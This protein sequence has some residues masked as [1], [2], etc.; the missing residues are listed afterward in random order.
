M[1]DFRKI[2]NLVKLLEA[3]SDVVRDQVLEEL[4]HCAAELAAY[5]ESSAAPPAPEV[6]Y[7]LDK[8][9][10]DFHDRQSIACWLDWVDERDEHAKLEAA[11]GFL[12]GVE[13][14]HSSA[15][16]LRSG[17]D[18]LAAEF[19]AAKLPVEVLMLN[20]YLFVEGRLRGVERNYYHP[21]H[22]NPCY[23]IEK[24]EGL[25]LS[26][27]VIFIL[28]GHRLG[29]AIHGFNSPGHFLARATVEGRHR[30]IDC[31]NG[32]VVIGE[33]KMGMLSGSS[34]I[35]FQH[36]LDHP[37][38][39]EEIVTR[40]LINL[41]NAYYRA[42]AIEKYNRVQGLLESLRNR[43][44][45]GLP[46][47]P[48]R[49][50]EK[51]SPLFQPGQLVH[52]KR[53]GYRGVVVDFDPSCHAGEHWYNSNLTQPKRDQ[54]WYHLL[55]DGS[56]MTTYAAE[57][58]LECDGSGREIEHPLITIYFKKFDRGHY[59]RNHVPWQLLQ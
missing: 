47:R 59:E 39:A 26:L 1:S 44:D 49:A 35:D 7:L 58:S 31:F 13:D 55:V 9:L 51:N 21:S 46:N 27:A 20:R 42:G 53:Y 22:S 24:G 4:R 14:G 12:A 54:P 32:G 15:A 36:L 6:M 5:L 45:T 56:N 19:L 8:I 28:T 43:L 38:T 37:P 18:R 50:A 33:A 48:V 10:R 2:E 11:L 29:L 17:L 25:P 23:V 30:L 3:E 16:D 52:H 57:S 34:K 41:V 40:V